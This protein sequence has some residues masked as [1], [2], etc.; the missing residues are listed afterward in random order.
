MPASALLSSQPLGQGTIPGTDL[1]VVVP[2]EQ[3]RVRDVMM[4]VV[5]G[6]RERGWKVRTVP[7][8]VIASEQPLAQ[9]GLCI[10]KRSTRY[11]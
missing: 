10:H 5:A 9:D 3:G 1:V 7:S 6:A 2:G 4:D 11:R 8:S